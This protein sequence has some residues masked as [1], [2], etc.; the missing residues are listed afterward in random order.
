MG[1]RPY[2]FNGCYTFFKSFV[3]LAALDANCLCDVK[4]VK[5]KN[6]NNKIKTK[7]N[8]KKNLD[9]KI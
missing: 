6:K 7:V 4:E 9:R 2:L 8:N 5:K 1:P 3:F